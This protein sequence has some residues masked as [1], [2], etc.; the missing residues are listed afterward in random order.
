MLREWGVRNINQALIID[1]LTSASTWAKPEIIDGEVYY[2]VARQKIVDELWVLDIKKDTAYR[3][4]KKIA[5][6][7]IIDYIKKG[8]KDCIRMTEKG[9]KYISKHYVGNESEF[10]QKLGNESE[11]NSEMNPTYNNTNNN[12]VSDKIKDEFNRLWKDYSLTFLKNLGRN[13]GS[14][15]KAF[16][17]YKKLVKKYSCADIYEFVNFHAG[18]KFG[19]KNLENLLRLDRYKQYLEDEKNIR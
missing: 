16:E 11:Y 7:G 18:L 2:W 17:G 3:H 10:D 6:L 5:E 4:L 8:K 15:A 14:K 19:H 12:L 13:G 9:K 1:L